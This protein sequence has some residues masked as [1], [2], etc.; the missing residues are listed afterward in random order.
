MAK[1]V[2]DNAFY[3]YARLGSLTE[4][5]GDPSE[6]SLDVDEFHHRQQRRHATFPSTQ[7]ALTTHDTK[8]GEDVRA[9]LDVLS[10]LPHEWQST[11]RSLRAAAPIGDGAFEQLLWQ[12]VIGAWPASRERL[13]AYA[14]KAAR[15]AGRS[16]TWTAPSAAFE[17]A[18]HAAIDTVFD[19]SRAFRL[20]DDFVAIVQAPGWSNALAAKVLQLTGPG[21][22]DVYQGS[23]LWET[24]L[25]DPDNRR[26]VDFESR[27]SMLD[28][29]D[30]GH[31]PPID[32]TGA[33][34]LLVTSRALRLRRDNPE[35]F[36]RHLPVE[37]IG[38]ARGHVVAFDRGGAVAV[39]TRL[40]VGL[41]RGGGWGNS[42][43][44]L[45]RRPMHD[46]FTGQCFE[47]GLTRV[48]D[49]LDRYPVALLAPA[50][51]VSDQEVTT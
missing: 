40:P 28:R 14:E 44:V 9:R 47:G 21:V 12:A 15:E 22:P 39:A 41:Q 51:S 35:W 18:M 6:F 19:D 3:R 25:V 45:A 26:P 23:E 33:V 24:S 16:T 46:V 37:A 29:L 8:R 48:A 50:A 31:L 34:K 4:V 43:I 36:T 11:L 13:H 20:V 32:E 42:E 7:T 30:E 10:E 2:E 17:G 38:P 27:R 1:G 5:G 49:L